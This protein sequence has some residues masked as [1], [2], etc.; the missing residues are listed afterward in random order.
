MFHRCKPGKCAW[1]LVENL[2]CKYFSF[3]LMVKVHM[4]C[5]YFELFLTSLC[6]VVTWK[7]LN[8]WYVVLNQC[9]DEGKPRGTVIGIDLQ[10]IQPIP[11]AIV[12]DNCDVTSSKTQ[13]TIRRVLDGRPV[14]VILS[15][16]APSATGV[17]SLDHDQIVQLAMTVLHM[18][19]TLLK[20]VGL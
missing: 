11:G 7:W 15:D 14:D 18:S 19:L 9:T 8:E 4:T 5:A 1:F 2:H 13:Q 10:S 17:S 12:L 3:L 20:E 6:I 16:M